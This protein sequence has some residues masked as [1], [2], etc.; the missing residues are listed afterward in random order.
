[1]AP[2]LRR[3]FTAAAYPMWEGFNESGVAALSGREE[4]QEIEK[5]STSQGNRTK[6]REN[7]EVI[8]MEG[9][10]K[11]IQVAGTKRMILLFFL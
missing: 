8:I 10:D 7:N 9:Y 6:K 4:T 1:M 5:T 3:A 2:A 11:E